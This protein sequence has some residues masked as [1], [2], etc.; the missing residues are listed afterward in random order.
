MLLLL[1]W[2]YRNG[3]DVKEKPEDSGNNSRN[4]NNTFS[5]DYLALIVWPKM[6]N[7]ILSEIL[8]IPQ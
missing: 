6:A 2:I 8:I 5:K 1:K 4:V 7:M 3:K